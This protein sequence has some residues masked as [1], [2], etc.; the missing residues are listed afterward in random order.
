MRPTRRPHL[1]QVLLLVLASSS[2]ALAACGSGS[3]SG[4]TTSS[5]SP[6]IIGFEAPLT[7][8]AAAPGKQEV[9]GWDLGL[10]VFGDSV[11]GHKIITYV[12]DTGGNPAVALSDARSLV[13][14]KHIQVM[15]GPLLA[16]EDAAVAP[17]LGAQDVPTDN[18]AV[19]GQ[20][21]IVDDAK[22][23]NAM[24]SGWLC[25]QPDIIAA[26]Y[27]YNTLGYRHVTVVANDY[28]F[29]WLSAGGFIKQFT[30]LGGK[31]D[32]VLWPPLTTVDFSPYVSAIPKN[33]QAVFAEVVGAG[34]IDFTKA[35]A[36]YGL[37]GK[38]PLYGNTL[39]F[40]YS[41]LP[42]EVP[43]DVLGDE[44][45]GQYCDGISSPANNR[46]V[47]LFD[48]AYH[49]RPGYYAEASYVHAEL[50]VDALK[51]LHGN[52]TN[53]KTLIAAM[54]STTVVAPRGPVTLNLT[55]DAP[56]QNIYVCK[57][58]NVHGT[59]EDVPIKTYPNVLPWGTLPYKTWQQEYATDST[60]APSA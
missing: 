29:G 44:Q 47:S 4:T 21:Q 55:V 15:E 24:A 18:L 7:G 35:Y 54:K 33:T 5:T 17:F 22:Y 13:L 27:L 45:I 57:V 1:P 48:A 46:F 52:A 60:G 12:D 36:Q 59:L 14:Q 28:A 38:I 20:T 9:Q 3:S 50:V 58:E 8:T 32:K 2:L 56:T 41:V 34:A 43:S 49:V 42:G 10:K 6:I 37:R 16:S 19:C 39:L 11:D 23:G 51:R 53:P 31:I 25:D 26:D 40:D 30:L